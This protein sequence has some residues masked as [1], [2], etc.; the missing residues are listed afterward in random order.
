VPFSAHA[1]ALRRTRT[2]ASAAQTTCPVLTLELDTVSLDLLGLHVDLSKVVL[3]ITADERRSPWQAVLQ[4]G[5]RQDGGSLDHGG[6]SADSRGSSQRPIDTGSRLRHTDPAAAGAWP[7]SVLDCRPSARPAASRA[8]RADRRSEP[9]SSTDHGRSERRRPRQPLVHHCAAAVH[10][11][12]HRGYD[13]VGSRH[14]AETATRQ[15]RLRG[16]ASRE[17]ALFALSRTPWLGRILR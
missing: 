4:S 1:T 10:H 17:E 16:V 2:L 8:T 12:D 14:S 7:R 6:T 13:L 3:T 5:Q 9:D 11:R 15:P